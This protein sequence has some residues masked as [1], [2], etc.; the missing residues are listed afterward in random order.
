MEAA[1]QLP[2]GRRFD[3]THIV[4]EILAKHNDS[5]APD[6]H[7]KIAGRIMTIRRMGKAGFAHLL[8]GGERLQLYIKKDALPKKITTSSAPSTWAT[9]SAPRATSSAQEPAN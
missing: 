3:F 1:G 5:P 7:V 8:Q 4:P 6:E 9:S 2:Y